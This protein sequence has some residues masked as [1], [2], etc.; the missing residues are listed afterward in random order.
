MF[1]ASSLD[2]GAE[3]VVADL[4]N[5]LS[6]QGVEVVVA[7]FA[8]SLW[9][10]RLSDK[11][12]VRPLTSS[13]EWYDPRLYWQ[14]RQII[15][16][17]QPDLVHSHGAKASKI[18]LRTGRLIGLTQVATKHN[19][20]KGKVFN[21]LPNVTAVSGKV[22]ESVR[23]DA[24]VIYN[25]VQRDNSLTPQLSQVM[26]DGAFTVLAVGR[27]DPIKRFDHLIRA[28]AQ[29]PADMRLQ[30]VGD[31]PQR[32]AL[33][34]LIAELGAEDR[35][36]LLGEQRDVPTRM[37]SAHLVVIASRS[38]G[39]SLVMVEALFY[40][41]LFMSTEVGAAPELLPPELLI[42]EGQLAEKLAQAQRDYG[43]MQATFRAFTAQQA[44]Q[45]ELPAVAAAYIAYYQR[46]LEEHAA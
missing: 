15:A 4:S 3:K 33:E 29:Q 5:S 26:A 18:V 37:A 16:Q 13:E 35:V 24:T 43:E 44:D 12:T 25:G 32:E 20:R 41:N 8:N 30:I 31:G 34:T 9:L 21:G 7:A 39:F 22:A 42:A 2:G 36:Q 27:L 23:G 19:S 28:V 17:E 11:V 1:I 10:K 6:L 38:E 40:A 45:F 46:I 14:L